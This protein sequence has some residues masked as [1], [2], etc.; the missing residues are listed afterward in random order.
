MRAGIQKADVNE[1]IKKKTKSGINYI[2][3][4]R[5]HQIHFLL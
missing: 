2:V 3:I 4:N 5:L 1:S